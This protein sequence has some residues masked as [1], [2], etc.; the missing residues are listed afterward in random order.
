MWLLPTDSL[1]PL[2]TLDRMGKQTRATAISGDKDPIALPEY[3]Q[4]YIAK[5][6]TLGIPASMIVLPEKGHEILDDPAVIAHVS[7]AVRDG[8]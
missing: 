2:H 5:A 1:S 6:R 3:A 7:Q 4:D 8:R